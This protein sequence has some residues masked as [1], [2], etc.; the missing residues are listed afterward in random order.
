MEFF[1]R[2][3]KE[4][5]ILFC[6]I[7]LLL[8]KFGCLMLMLPLSWILKDK[9]GKQHSLPFVGSNLG[10][11]IFLRGSIKKRCVKIEYWGTSVYF[12]LR[13]QQNYMQSLSAY[14]GIKSSI[15]FHSLIIEFLWFALLWLKILIFLTMA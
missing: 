13:F 5:A 8:I 14:E 2:Y 12:V 15:F 7:K 6:L 4:K 10:V 11:G 9:G 1:K 3:L